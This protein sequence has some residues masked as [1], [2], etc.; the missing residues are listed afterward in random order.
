MV[1]KFPKKN[2]VAFFFAVLM[3]LAGYVKAEAYETS[4]LRKSSA[5]KTFPAKVVQKLSIPKGYHEGLSVNDGGLI[6]ANGENGK[7]WSI[8]PSSGNITGTIEPI[9]GFTESVVP[10]SGNQYFVTEWDEKKLYRASL[11]DNKLVPEVW[12][13]VKPAHPAGIV[14]T[15]EKLY[16]IMW[17]RGLGTKFDILSIDKNLSLAERVSIQIIEEPTQLAWDGQ[18]LWV[19]SWFDSMVYKVDVA[20]WETI[21]AFKSPVSRTTGIAWDGNFLWLTGTHSDLYK[22]EISQ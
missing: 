16:L 18:Y 1:K 22:M 21:G 10:F 9:G 6:L 20:R 12:V 2:E 13:S 8:D 5:Y 17:T 3:L 7:I 19:S 4:L 14:W 11:I 15:G